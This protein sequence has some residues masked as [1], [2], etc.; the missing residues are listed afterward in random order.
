MHALTRGVHVAVAGGLLVSG[1]AACRLNGLGTVTVHGM[2]AEMPLG[3]SS[4]TV[5]GGDQVTIADSSGKVLA[6]PRLGDTPAAKKYPM[7]LGNAVTEQAYPFSATVPAEP[8]YRITA[9]GH[10]MYFVSEVQFEDGVD[11]NC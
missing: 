7:G 10:E 11:L 4:C 5:K 9:E 8:G 3:G 1:L 6:V 2:L